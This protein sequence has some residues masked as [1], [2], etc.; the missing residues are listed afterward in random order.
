MRVDQRLIPPPVIPAKVGIQSIGN[1]THGSRQRGG[2]LASTGVFPSLTG[3]WSLAAGV[4]VT[5]D[6]RVRGN[7]ELWRR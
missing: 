7:D 5:L 3:R 2:R 6:S 1:A 4:L